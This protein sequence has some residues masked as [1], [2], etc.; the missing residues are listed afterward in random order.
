M[1][2]YEVGPRDG[3]QA[4]PGVV[5]TAVKAELCRRLAA[6]GVRRLEV[7]SFVAPRWVPALADAE[8]LMGQL[9]GRLDAE[10]VCLVPNRRG[11]QRAVAAGATEVAVLTSATDTF[12]RANLNT[13]R[14][15]ALRAA[16]E[17][18]GLVLDAGLRV[19]GYVSM[20]FA[21]PWE[22]PVD[23]AAV[24]GIGAALHGAG[25]RTVS[26]GDTI[27]AATPG[28]VTAV[29]AALGAAGVPTGALALHG[30]DTYGQALAN[31]YAALL[32]GVTEFDASV[33]GL[34]RCPYAP[35]ATGNLATEDLVWML[36]GLGIA[37]GLDLDQL[38]RTSAWLAART[39]RAGIAS[40]AAT[41]LLAADASATETEGAAT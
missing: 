33:G 26:L 4:E 40:R 6:A 30:H 37:T 29:V 2:V 11:L 39:G 35:G 16:V 32:A 14:D 1:T 25:C 12:A 9:R 22:G 23:P 7:T 8:A 20:A 36:H 19:R 28:H 15:G 3:L 24:A 13:D 27:G 10:T 31:V 5:P 38:V 21:D 18:T 17:L 41:A 34:G